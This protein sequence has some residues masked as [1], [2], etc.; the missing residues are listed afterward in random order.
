MGSEGLVTSNF[1]GAQLP[2]PTIMELVGDLDIMELVRDLDKLWG[3]SKDWTLQL[4]DGR[5]LVLP[6]IVSFSRLFVSLFKFGGRVYT[7]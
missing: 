7:R 6:F 5:Q 4:R 1:E 3:N 2:G